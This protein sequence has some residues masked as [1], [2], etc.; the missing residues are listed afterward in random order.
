MKR[1]RFSLQAVHNLREL[2]REEAER[3][4]VQAASAVTAAASAIEAIHKLRALLEGEISEATGPLCIADL[5]L[6]MDYL[7]ALA[8]READARSQLA[9]L[10]QECETQREAAVA[11]A[12]EAEVTG[13]LRARRQDRHVS[14]NARIEQNFLDEMGITIVLRGGRNADE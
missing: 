12:R 11:A 3:R 2:R 13:Q 4:F 8:R 6:R 7:D 14:E 10:E 9:Q 1:F 5:A